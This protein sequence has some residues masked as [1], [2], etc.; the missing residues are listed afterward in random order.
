M[1]SVVAEMVSRISGPIP[2]HP[3][4]EK[5][6]R[7]SPTYLK[8]PATRVRHEAEQTSADGHES[9]SL[10]LEVEGHAMPSAYRH[11]SLLT[12]YSACTVHCQTLH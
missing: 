2:P 1:F 4:Y 11:T 9:F 3:G 10:A 12:L 6:D 5:L 7:Q 8:V